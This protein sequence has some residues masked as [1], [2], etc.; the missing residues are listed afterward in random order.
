MTAEQIE[1]ISNLIM[2]FGKYKGETIADVLAVD[3]K[4]LEWLV[5][6]TKQDS[7]LVICLEEY[8]NNM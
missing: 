7:A 8:L 5:A 1:R 2:P 6:N 4:Y 3:E